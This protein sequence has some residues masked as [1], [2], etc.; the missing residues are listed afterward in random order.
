ME[1]MIAENHKGIFADF[2]SDCHY[3]CRIISVSHF[4]ELQEDIILLKRA[5]LLCDQEIF[6]NILKDMRFELPQDFPEARSVIVMAVL[7]RPM[8]VNFHLNGVVHEIILPHQYYDDGLTMDMIKNEIAKNVL[9]EPCHRL[10][11]G[12]NLHLKLLAVRS[13][14]GK[15]GRNNIFY[16]KGLGSFLALHALLTDYEFK[17]DNWQEL[18]MLEMCENCTI[19]RKQCPTGAIRDYPF[20]IDVGKCLSLYNENERDLPDWIPATTHNALV[21]CMRCQITC[22]A[23]REALKYIGRFED[24]QES[25]TRQFLSGDPEDTVLRSIGKKLKIRHMVESKEGYNLLRRNLSLL[26]PKIE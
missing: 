8:Y 3:Y 10:E 11:R 9:P 21:G 23:N 17:E 2:A 14:L 12:V 19:C 7:S 25:E 20:I 26:L 16:A 1:D 18:S 5:N 6:Q 22:P 15:Y 4:K 24:I 13:G